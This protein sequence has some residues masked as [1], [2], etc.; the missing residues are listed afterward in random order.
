MK[1]IRIRRVFLALAAAFGLLFASS[2]LQAAGTA[3]KKAPKA[4]DIDVVICLDVSSSMD[5][6]VDSARQ[7]LWDIV[8]DLA[9]VK[10]TPNL[11]VGLYSYGHTTYDRNAGWVRKEVDLTNDLDEIYRKLSALTL[12]GG[13]EYVA[14]VCQDAI[15]Q[16]A[17]SK[18]KD[19]LK[20]IF[21]CGNE[22]ASQDPMVKLQTVGD[23][24]QKNGIIINPIFAGPANASD[25][26]D[27]KQ[28]AIMAKGVFASID[29]DRGTVV[30]AAPQ[31]KKLSELMSKLNTTYVAYGKDAKMKQSNQAAQD[32]NANSNAGAAPARAMSKAS[33]LYRNDSWDLVDRCKNDPKFDIKKVPVEQLCDE[34]KKLTPDQR[35]A[36]VKE[37]ASK[38]EAMQKEIAQLSAERSKYIQA[39]MKKNSSKADKAFDSAVRNTLRNQAAT[40]GIEIPK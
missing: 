6:L 16:Q 8:N 24:A 40:K 3:G 11:R 33:A 14:R 4:K 30:V 34:L 31:D 7:K 28:F 23:L 21:V 22:P 15:N 20:I 39:E 2:G 32:G 36:F 1:A 9:K 25:A 26:A 35:V 19:A 13:E 17:W 27:W 38:R 29:Q 18:D 5:G 10:P 12:N 37:Q